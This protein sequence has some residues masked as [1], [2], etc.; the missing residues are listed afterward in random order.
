MHAQKKTLE[1][2]PGSEKIYYDRTS[3]R[4]RL[5]GTVSFAY[6]G[7]TMYC[8]SAHYQD[9]EKIVHAYGN[10]HIRKED[11]NLYCDSLFYDE[12]NKYAKLWGD[13]RVRDQE[14]KLS[15]D[16]L[17]YDAKRGRAIYR[18]KGRIE[19]IVSNERITS[20]LGYFY[21]NNYLILILY[22]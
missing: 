7:N 4:H 22:S 15:S 11:V 20:T 5:V 6:H 2:L 1:L 18:N 21:P 19:S 13:V 17:D 9:K 12:G 10:V 8:D 16:S 14:Y 3:G